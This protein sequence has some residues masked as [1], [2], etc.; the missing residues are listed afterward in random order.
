MVH[1]LLLRLRLSTLLLGPISNHFSHLVSLVVCVL[2][3][4][5]LALSAHRFTSILGG[6]DACFITHEDVRR[7]RRVVVIVVVVVNLELS[8]LPGR[9]E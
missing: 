1:L 4:N 3:L 5:E 2:R 7:S 9:L 8:V 6:G